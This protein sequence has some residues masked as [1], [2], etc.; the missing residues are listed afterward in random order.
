M[1]C[2]HSP[3]ASRR[4][5]FAYLSRALSVACRVVSCP[6]V[7]A[8]GLVLQPRKGVPR[9]PFGLRFRAPVGVGLGLRH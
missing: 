5:L 9:R 3:S 6:M 4:A 8:A 7:D 2:S 1:P